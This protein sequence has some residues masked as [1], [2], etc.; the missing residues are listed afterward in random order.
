M[1]IHE[2]HRKRLKKQFRDG[3]LDNFSEFQILELLLFYA[4]PRKDTNPIAHRL[5][6]RFGSLS[7]VLEAPVE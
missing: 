5:I 1:S 7:Q 6:D 4:I 2:D 3:G